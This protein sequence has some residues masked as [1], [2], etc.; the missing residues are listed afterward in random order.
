MR[1]GTGAASAAMVFLL[2]LAAQVL[3]LK[4]SLLPG[5]AHD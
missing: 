4:V 5:I 1:S 3:A 2:M